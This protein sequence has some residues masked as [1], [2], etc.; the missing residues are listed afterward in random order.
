MESSE[1]LDE[2][3]SA[4][5]LFTA[6]FCSGSFCVDGAGLRGCDSSKRVVARPRPRP[7][8]ALAPVRALDSTVDEKRRRSDGSRRAAVSTDPRAAGG[9]DAGV[10]PS[11]AACDGACNRACNSTGGAPARQSASVSP[12]LESDAIPEAPPPPPERGNSTGASPTLLLAPQAPAPPLAMGVWLFSWVHFATLYSY[13]LHI[14]GPQVVSAAAF[15][16]VMQDL[17]EADP[18]KVRRRVAQLLL[19]MR[20]NANAEL[21]L[22]GRGDAASTRDAA[23]VRS[24]LHMHVDERH[25]RFFACL[26]RSFDTLDS[27]AFLRLFSNPPPLLLD[28]GR[29]VPTVR[30]P[31]M[32][33]ESTPFCNVQQALLSN[34][35]VFPR[36]FVHFLGMVMFRT[37]ADDASAKVASVWLSTD[38]SLDTFRIPPP[39]VQG[40]SVLFDIQ[41][42]YILKA[43]KT[44]LVFIVGD[45]P[46]HELQADVKAGWV[47]HR[48][49]RTLGGSAYPLTKDLASSDVWPAPPRDGEAPAV[50]PN[51]GASFGATDALVF[52]SATSVWV[53]HAMLRVRAAATPQEDAQLA[54]AHFDTYAAYGA[55][56]ATHT[57]PDSDD[58]LETS[59]DDMVKKMKT[60]RLKPPFN[61]DPTLN[62]TRST[63]STPTGW[64]TW[65]RTGPTACASS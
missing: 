36:K 40:S 25:R 27:V 49:H 19:E 28:Y 44:E 18:E 10:P 57:V 64:V 15:T 9:A 58:T 1:H 60:D 46:A 29:R 41:D 8:L 47:L 6:S 32:R 7:A 35:D 22:L 2:L 56:A 54:A 11:A 38:A 16:A 48:E 21:N 45:T 59:R 65:R 42:E 14:E 51:V 26:A 12:D 4:F 43:D 20:P 23:L 5:F 34:R 39:T 31:D 33:G 24:V 61:S 17:E 62:E 63:C 3:E 55:H 37:G 30:V 52:D 50:D 53:R 13:T